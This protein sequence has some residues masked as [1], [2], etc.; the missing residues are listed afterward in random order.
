[1]ANSVC[2]TPYLRNHAWYDCHLWYTSGN[3]WYL[4]VFFQN[5][6][7]LD[8][9]WGKRAKK[10]PKM[11]KNSVSLTLYSKEPYTIWLWILVHMRKM[12]LSPAIFFIFPKILIFWVFRGGGGGKRGKNDL[13]LPISVCHALYLRN[14]RSYH[15]DV[16]YTRVK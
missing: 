10:W 11:T 15:L 14:C 6:D 16:R 2:H 3:Q 7:F 1:M 4:Q 8:C 13:K 12:I 9:Q 5:F